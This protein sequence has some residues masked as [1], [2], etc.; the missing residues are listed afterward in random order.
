MGCSLRLGILRMGCC[1]LVDRMRFIMSVL[2]SFLKKNNVHPN[3][4]FC[5]LFV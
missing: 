2:F 5:A 4:F 3:S 1:I